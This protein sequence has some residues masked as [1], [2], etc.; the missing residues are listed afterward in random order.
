MIAAC[1]SHGQR[2]LGSARNSGRRAPASAAACARPGPGHRPARR[3]AGVLAD[4]VQ[5]RMRSSQ[6]RP[7]LVELQEGDAHAG[8]VVERLQVER[9]IWARAIGSPRL[10]IR[11]TGAEGRAGK[12]SALPLGGGCKAAKASCTTQSHAQRPAH[13]AGNGRQA[14]VHVRGSCGRGRTGRPGRRACRRS[15]SGPPRTR[16]QA[17]RPTRSPARLCW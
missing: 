1:P 3:A 10:A 2:R 12:A 14:A 15:L 7:E 8:L 4:G 17:G 5:L 16:A 11:S 9:S 13:A 6:L